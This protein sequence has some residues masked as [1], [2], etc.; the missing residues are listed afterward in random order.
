MFSLIFTK[1]FVVLSLNLFFGFVEPF[2]WGENLFI[3]HSQ[4]PFFSSP[5]TAAVT[6]AFSV[7]PSSFPSI[8]FFFC[9]WFTIFHTSSL[10]LLHFCYLSFT[11]SPAAAD[12]YTMRF[13]SIPFAPKCRFVIMF[14]CPGMCH[15]PATA[16]IFC[17]YFCELSENMWVS[18]NQL[19]TGRISNP[20][21]INVTPDAV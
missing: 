20:L 19:L 17:A 15:Y 12:C 4:D 18:C 2:Y 1:V 5:G 13:L 10:M 3:Y 7:P 6:S 11:F 9:V 8:K 21:G 16:D 14:W